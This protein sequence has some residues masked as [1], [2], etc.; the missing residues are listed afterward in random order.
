MSD[1]TKGGKIID[2]K[3]ADFLNDQGKESKE[4]R[5]E[6]V[7]KRRKEEE[8]KELAEKAGK[9]SQERRGKGNVI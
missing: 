4:R 7:E 1:N 9:E 2:P 6:A 8:V 3:D 5:K